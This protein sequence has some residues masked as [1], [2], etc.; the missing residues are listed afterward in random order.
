[1]EYYLAV[2]ALSLMYIF[3]AIPAIGAALSQY[4]YGY[5]DA[6][7]QGVYIHFIIGGI[8][9]IFCALIWALNILD[10]N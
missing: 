1:M 4:T 8:C 9:S 7:A 5:W 6:F 10:L 2:T 3:I